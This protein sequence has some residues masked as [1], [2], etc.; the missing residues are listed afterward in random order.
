MLHEKLLSI[1]KEFEDACIEI[2]HTECFDLPIIQLR[3]DIFN[4]LS[5]SIL[6][7]ENDFVFNGPEDEILYLS[8]IHI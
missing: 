8:L 2:P 4:E 6:K 7:I 3:R 5:D 1:L